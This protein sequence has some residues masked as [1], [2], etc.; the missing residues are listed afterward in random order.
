MESYVLVDSVQ[1]T[2]GVSNSFTYTLKNVLKG[3]HK[4]ELLSAAFPQLTSCT[5]VVLDITEFRNTRNVN[6]NFGVIN[7]LIPINGNIAYTSK[8]FYP[9]QTTFDNPFDIGTLTVTWRDPTGKTILMNDNS[10]LL[11][12]YHMK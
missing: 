3:V 9:I 10:I 11:K 8:S 4:V 1:K 12:I 2:S 5:H 6:S 7:N